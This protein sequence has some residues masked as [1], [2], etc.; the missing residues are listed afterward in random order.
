MGSEW[1]LP[2]YAL[3]QLGEIEVVEDIMTE[4]IFNYLLEITVWKMFVCKHF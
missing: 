3:H 4:T 2:E 1:G